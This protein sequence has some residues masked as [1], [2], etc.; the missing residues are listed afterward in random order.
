MIRYILKKFNYYK[1]EKCG[2]QLVVIDDIVIAT[3]EREKIIDKIL[4]IIY[5]CTLEK[6]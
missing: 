1:L 3:Y 4:D 6:L 5:D 2:R